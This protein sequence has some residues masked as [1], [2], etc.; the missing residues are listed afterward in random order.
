MRG[1]SKKDTIKNEMSHQKRHT[2]DF[3][4]RSDTKTE[5]NSLALTSIFKI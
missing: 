1:H 5:R 3:N 2:Q 4:M